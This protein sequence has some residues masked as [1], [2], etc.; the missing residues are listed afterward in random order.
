M[1]VVQ[2]DVWLCGDC[3]ISAETGD[4]SSLDYH[5]GEPE[6]SRRQ[7]AVHRGLEALGP[8]L[9]PDYDLEETWFDCED[10]RHRFRSQDGALIPDPDDEN[11]EDF[12]LACPDCFSDSIRERDAGHE[13][14]STSDCDCCG[15]S[16]AGSR[17]RFAIL[18]E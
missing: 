18:G 16:L 11:G 6:A 4:D 2:E 13:E 17:W 10:C 5:Y 14:F 12:L 15:T 9:V 8:N 1:K 7:A 3:C